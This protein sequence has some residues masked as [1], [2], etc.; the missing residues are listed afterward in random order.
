VSVPLASAAQVGCLLERGVDCYIQTQSL[1][2]RVA[3]GWL[4][5]VGMIHVLFRLL[6]GY[7]QGGS[8]LSES[9]KIAS[10]PLH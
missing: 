8:N 4:L 5:K 10:R 6:C 2:P 1:V 7:L 9:T 3:Y